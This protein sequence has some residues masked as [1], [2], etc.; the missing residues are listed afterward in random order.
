MTKILFQKAVMMNLAD[1]CTLPILQKENS[2]AYLQL[3]SFSFFLHIGV[4][5]KRE[6][7]KKISSDF[8]ALSSEAAAL[9][10]TEHSLHKGF[11]PSLLLTSSLTMLW[12]VECDLKILWKLSK[13]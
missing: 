8:L 11:W 4:Y 5:S 1:T 3:F 13:L 2:N 10:D 9:T 6:K 7:R 12:L